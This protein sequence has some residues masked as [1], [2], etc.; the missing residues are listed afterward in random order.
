MKWLRSVLAVVLLFPSI[1]FASDDPLQGVGTL[2]LT[3][4]GAEAR[5]Q[6]L[7]ARD[8]FA[9]QGKA[10]EEAGAWLLLGLA[11]TSIG[12]GEA[13]RAALH[14]SAEKFTAAGDFFGAWLSLW[15]IATLERQ[16]AATSKAIAA[17]ERLFEILREAEA[18][19][20]RFSM[21]S[22]RTIGPVF[23]ANTDMLGPLAAHPE[24]MKPILLRFTRTISHDSYA[25]LLID[26]GDLDAAEEELRKASEMATLFGGLF[27]GSIAL[28]YAQLRQ[29]Q[30]RLDEARDYYSKS[31]RNAQTMAP[32][33]TP[34]VVGA[35][36]WVEMNVLRN[37]AEL[38]LLSGRLD[39]A[40]AWND[41]ALKLIRE[42]G[43]PK[44]E[45]SVLR[46][47]ADLLEKGGRYDASLPL[48]EDALKLATQTSHRH[49]QAQIH[50]DL[51]AAHMLRG[52]Y[53]TAAKHLEKSIALYQALNESYL[54][55]PTWILLAQVYT[56]LEAD[57][58]AEI[59][60]ENADK[61]AEKSEFGLA[62]AMV[63]VM[64]KSRKM[65]RGR[66][67][68]S[69]ADAAFRAMLK[70]PDAQGM[71]TPGMTN[72]LR[73]CA[74]LAG[75]SKSEGPLPLESGAPSFMRGLS[76][77]LQGISAL[78]S[79]EHE[80][81]RDH[82]NRALALNPSGDHKAGMFGMI[83]V[84]HSIEGNGEEA[85]RNFRRAADALDVS[86]ADVK[87]EELLTSYL[88]S[89]RRWYFSLLVDMLVAEGKPLEAFAHAERARA[90]TFL[91]MIGNHRLRAAA[92][93]DPRLVAETENMRAAIA[94][95]E[96]RVTAAKPEE[97]ALI[98]ADLER[99]REH[100]RALLI[101]MKT[102]NPEYEDLTNV[103]PRTI[104]SVR[105]ELSPDTTLISY[106]VSARVVH[107]WVV[108]REAAHHQLLRLDAAALTPLLCW[109]D[110]L[111]S[112]TRGVLVPD[113]PCDNNAASPADAYRALIA[114]LR[115]HIRHEKLVLVPHGV[116]HYIPFAA[117]LDPDSNRY[118]VQDYTLTYAP[119]ASSLRFLRAKETPVDGGAVVLGDPVTSLP[120]LAPLPGAKDEATFVARTL[121]TTPRL[122]ADA[123]ETLLHD[124]Q[125]KAD[126]VHVAAHALYDASHPLFS[127]IALAADE[128]NDGSLTVTEILST[129][130]LEGVNLV[131]LSACRSAVGQR[132]GGDEIVGLTRALLYAGTPG[133][134]S[135]LW[136]IDDTSAAT[137]M[138]AFYRRLGEGVTAAE[139][140]RD[141]Q[142]AAI[143]SDKDPRHWSAFMLTGDPQ[144]RWKAAPAESR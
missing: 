17:F 95:R 32:M 38:E 7:K 60:L 116:L 94:D 143:E 56:L 65:M 140:L 66:G 37:L 69:E 106:Y 48:F 124:L 18:P 11:E 5:D 64:G 144:G 12:Y 36:P 93:A 3:G 119:S 75:G 47:R 4:R 76:V 62:R 59:A 136:N 79:G 52:A 44:R 39:E 74:L 131:V 115:K 126:L 97:A 132:S 42:R 141:A 130:D 129:V 134:I 33:F 40:L 57:G 109:A 31:L 100:Y 46:D 73:E 104:E 138:T 90:R 45:A 121:G 1:G 108:D 78:R 137:L 51:G 123:R 14:Q 30:W 28:H 71:F 15:S 142:I 8:I 50:G 67:D 63:D 72:L 91:Q 111:A 23:G 96:R 89:N 107:A 27:D 21:D 9:A 81:A 83:G 70:L 105:E 84:S 125:G 86:A 49:L 114:P 68:A 133:V 16:D 80:K 102:T 139:A 98:E 53:G 99:A 19:G 20:A 24:I 88:G 13:A 35:D 55:A 92:S 128:K 112:T 26:I 127:R 85:I 43:D 110:E 22:L 117:L 122:G 54:E 2:L 41:R 29:M 34:P 25:K 58:N 77:M 118:L 10:E 113:R 101:R 87:V 82:F 103:E 120:G 61:L 6:L 135:T